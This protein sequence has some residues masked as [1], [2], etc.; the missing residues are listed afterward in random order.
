M[1]DCVSIH[2]HSDLTIQLLR[3]RKIGNIFKCIF[4][5]ENYGILIQKLLKLV[6]RGICSHRFNQNFVSIGLDN[7]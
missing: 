5:N 2:P 6:P 3:P 1:P 4:L 7:G